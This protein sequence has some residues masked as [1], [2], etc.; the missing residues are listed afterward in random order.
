MTIYENIIYYLGKRFK[1]V[2]SW[3]YHK[4]NYSWLWGIYGFL[5]NYQIKDPNP[6]NI[7]D[8]NKPTEW[9]DK[10]M[11]DIFKKDK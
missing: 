2:R 8:L 3:Y 10:H 1:F 11:E 4:Y 9:L 5:N 6:C 7:D